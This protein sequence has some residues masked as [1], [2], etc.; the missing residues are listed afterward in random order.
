LEREL[1]QPPAEEH[2]EGI[3][4][5]IDRFVLLVPDHYLRRVITVVN[6]DKS[7]TPILDWLI[8]VWHGNSRLPELSSEVMGRLL[9]IYLN[10]KVEAWAPVCDECGLERPTRPFG[11]PARQSAELKTDFFDDCP[12]CGCTEWTWTTWLQG[13]N[14]P[15]KPWMGDSPFH[16]RT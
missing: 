7:R 10:E 12:H 3:S 1:L 4:N 14:R 13:V 2:G 9:D 8:S 5:I 11:N 6:D 15:W 16:A